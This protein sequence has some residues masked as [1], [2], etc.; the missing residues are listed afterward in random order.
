MI[1]LTQQHHNRPITAPLVGPRDSPLQTLGLNQRAER[2]VERAQR[3]NER[4]LG[5]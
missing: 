4:P 5:K 3:G 1:D 2:R